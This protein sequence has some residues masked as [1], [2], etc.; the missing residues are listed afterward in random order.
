MKCRN[1][2]FMSKVG[3]DRLHKTTEVHFDV[4]KDLPDC[5]RS[6]TENYIDTMAAAPTF[7]TFRIPNNQFECMG[8]GCFNSGTL[9]N[10]GKATA[11]LIKGDA[12]AFSAGVVTFYV[13]PPAGEASVR[14][15]ISEKSDYAD[16]W[17]YI[18]P[19]ADFYTA[20][21]GY[22]AVIIDL[23]KTP[24]SVIGNGWTPDEY[25][26]Y[27][28]IEI[29]PTDPAE[30]M[31]GVGISSIGI[32]DEIADFEL[33]S[34][35]VMGCVTG[36]DGSWDLEPL[37]ATCFMGGFDADNITSF[38]KTITGKA[39]TPN[40]MV[41]NPLVTKGTAVR[42]SMNVTVQKTIMDLAGTDYGYVLIDDMNQDEC[43]YFSAAVA[44]VCN[45]TEAR[46]ERVSIPNKVD[47]EEKR[48][49][50][51]DNGDGT[52]TV[53]FNKANIGI[54]MLISYPKAVDV[55][56]VV[57]RDDVVNDKRMR[58]SYIK[59]HTDGVQYKFVFNN[60][61]VTSFPDAITEDEVEFSF[62]V[63]IQKDAAGNFGYAQRILG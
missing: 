1:D 52:T 18:L 63:Q 13:M 21:D 29:Q 34:H 19:L 8:D 58:M 33:S 12:T 50:L 59:T 49:Q 16:A 14:L 38:E 61:L 46:F 5:R 42:G 3:V 32:F 44:G 9:Y 47:L 23:S 6:S 31:S 26:T 36:I 37:E 48:Y 27:I 53:L 28:E 57:L 7:G 30:D 2:I 39:L 45:L 56:E 17:E 24:T 54:D 4:Q 35:V 25:N 15:K 62:T 60:V 20:A 40:Y 41:L 11:Y 55:E 22:K 43:G 51:L 10:E